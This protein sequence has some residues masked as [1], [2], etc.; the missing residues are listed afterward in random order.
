VLPADSDL[1]GDT[2]CLAITNFAEIDI[3]TSRATYDPAKGLLISIPT[4][5]PNF[6][7]G[8]SKQDRCST[9]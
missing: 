7:T 3:K 2:Q 6:E 9:S 8:K 5:I 1:L 4:R